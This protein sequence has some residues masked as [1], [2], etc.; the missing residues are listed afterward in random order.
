MVAG[1]LGN[2][3]IDG[4]YWTLQVELK[5]YALVFFLIVFKQIYNINYWLIGWLAGCIAA[6]FVPGL[7]SITIYPYG[8]YFIAGSTLYLIWIEKLT[9]TRGFILFACLI[10][11]LIETVKGTSDY[12]FDESSLNSIISA[13]IVFCFYV[14]MLA[15]AL[16][17]VRIGE[18]LFLFR[19]SM[20]TYPLYL[21]HNELGQMIYSHLSTNK[22]ISLLIALAL[23]FSLCYLLAMYV[24]RPL[25]RIFNKNLT[26]FHK[27]LT[28]L[29]AKNYKRS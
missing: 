14:L 7:S 19:L 20:M 9:H 12:I 11:S 3:Y 25:N 5:F 8:P 17:H 29:R 1:Y 13:L 24:D 16:G 27:K 22:Y 21:L 15:I 6:P 26:T 28:T 2:K 10:L 18:R 4:V 23:I